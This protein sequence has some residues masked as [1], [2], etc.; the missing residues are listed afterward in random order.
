[1]QPFSLSYRQRTCQGAAL[2]NAPRQPLQKRCYF[3]REW[4]EG[5]GSGLGLGI[6]STG[7]LIMPVPGSQGGDGCKV[8]LLSVMFRTAAVA[9]GPEETILD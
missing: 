6:V 7:L 5:A 3:G 1:M 4:G 8:A 2:S 9:T